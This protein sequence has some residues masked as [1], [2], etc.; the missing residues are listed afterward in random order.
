VDGSGEVQR[1]H[2]IPLRLGNLYRDA[3]DMML[4]ERPC[5]RLKCDCYIGYA[6][7]RDLPFE[8]DF[9]TGMLARIP[10]HFTAAEG[11]RTPDKY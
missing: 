6:H 5:S 3:L 7:R 4:R 2:F 9:G 11:E 10:L 1:C 8:R